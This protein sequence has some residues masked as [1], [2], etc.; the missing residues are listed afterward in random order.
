MKTESKK[1]LPIRR[2]RANAAP[3]PGRPPAAS[4]RSSSTQNRGPGDRNDP[5]ADGNEGPRRQRRA[6]SHVGGEVYFKGGSQ[7]EQAVLLRALD[8]SADED[9]VMI[10]VHGF[11]SYPARLHPA[12]ARGLI[13]GLSKKGDRVL[14]PFCGSGT[15]VVEA[16]ALDRHAIGSD[17]NPLAVELAWLKSRAPTQ[18]L[19]EEMLNA[20]SHIAEV[21]EDRRQA[22]ADPYLRYG[23]E[24][25]ERYPIHI[26]LELDSIAHGIGLVKKAEVERMLRL[27]VSST[28]TKLSHSEGDTTRQ[29]T[30]RRLPGGFAIQIFEQ[31]ANELAE[32]LAAYRSRISERSPK[33]YVGCSDARDLAKIESGSVDLI[34]TSPPYPG[35]YDY[36][37]HHMHRI[38]WLGLREGALRTGEIGARREYR[39]MRATEASERWQEEIGATL[40]E[41]RRTLAQ[42]GRGVIVVADSVVD[43]KAIRADEQLAAVAKRAGIDITCVASQERPLFLHGAEHA[44]RDRPRMEHVVIFRPSER[45]HRKDRVDRAINKEIATLKER[46][47]PA[48]FQKAKRDDGAS[49]AERPQRSSQERTWDSSP[50]GASRPRSNF[51]SKPK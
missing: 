15:V 10:D 34:I 21:A 12:T 11:H 32:R 39:H 17:L 49:R 30:P 37:D 14:D 48:R 22:K 3:S 4:S 33:A 43:K 5:N 1:H 20:A 42:D 19:V 18:K 6:L 16:K 41:L 28:L 40:F 47:R 46:E 13:E 29:R 27:V 2:T 50:S 25:R 44:F 51:G 26:L 8:V 35:V 7:E 38:R 31:K 9:E 23:E 45:D 24:D 36:L